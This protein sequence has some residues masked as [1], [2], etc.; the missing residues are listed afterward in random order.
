MF[1]WVQMLLVFSAL[2]ASPNW[3][4]ADRHLLYV[5]CLLWI[6]GSIKTTWKS[7]NFS[8]KLSSLHRDQIWT[9]CLCSGQPAQ[10]FGYR[11]PRCSLWCSGPCA[12]LS[13]G[14]SD[15]T[16][17]QQK[18][19]YAVWIFEKTR[20]MLTFLYTKYIWDVVKSLVWVFWASVTSVSELLLIF[21]TYW[22]S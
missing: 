17:W 19:L 20:L 21:L 14:W 6:N 2:I 15:Q 4:H 18:K 3:E 12:S 13:C 8:F 22:K 11:C 9:Y 7:L 5:I 10:I 16:K 1:G